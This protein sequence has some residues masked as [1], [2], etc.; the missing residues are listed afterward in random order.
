MHIL[1][2]RNDSSLSPP[3]ADQ[4]PSDMMKAVPLALAISAA[5]WAVAI[6][7]LILE[8]RRH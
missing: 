7:T 6:I 2:D 1:S 4:R 5:L 3:N 8:L